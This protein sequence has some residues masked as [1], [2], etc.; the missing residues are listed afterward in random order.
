MLYYLRLCY[1]IVHYIV[2]YC[3]ILYILIYI[4]I[5]LYIYTFIYHDCSILSPGTLQSGISFYAEYRIDS[6]GQCI[7][8]FPM[9][10]VSVCPRTSHQPI[11]IFQLF[12][13]ISCYIHLY[14]H[15]F[16]VKIPIEL[17]QWIDLRENPWFY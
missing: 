16:M 8:I 14:P 4:Y 1:S 3:I 12:S 10:L 5:H 11:I 17:L 2:L 7:V 9:I 15:I 13:I 6:K